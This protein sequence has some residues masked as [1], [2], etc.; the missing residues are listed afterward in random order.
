MDRCRDEQRVTPYKMVKEFNK[1]FSSPKGHFNNRELRTLRVN[2][3]KEE[4]NELMDALV[5]WNPNPSKVMK[6]MGDL[7]YVIIGAADAWGWDL[8]EGFRRIHESNMTKAEEDGTVNRRADGKILKSSRYS[9]P[10]L[11]GLFGKGY[12]NE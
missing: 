9:P 5:D 3:I 4:F 2:L 6:E 12:V 8:E 10:I 1:T 7:I 11:D